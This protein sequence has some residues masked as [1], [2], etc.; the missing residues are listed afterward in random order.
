MV[1]KKGKKFINANWN[2]VTLIAFQNP[3]N[4]KN[5]F[6]DF[7]I[8]AGDKQTDLISINI[9]KL[10]NNKDFKFNIIEFV[11]YLE[12]VSDKKVK[13]GDISFNKYSDINLLDYLK[14]ERS[15]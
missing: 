15:L 11:E 7:V 14:I 10:Q 12:E 6:N 3:S 1:Y 8:K 13:F 9:L 2:E 5:T 4:R